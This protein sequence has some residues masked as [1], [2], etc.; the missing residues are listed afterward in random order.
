MII[1]TF[2]QFL[3]LIKVRK[4]FSK[5]VILFY[6]GFKDAFGF[7]LLFVLVIVIF[8]ISY[9]VLGA[10]MDDS[11]NFESSYDTSH[12]DYPFI[13]Y[14]AVSFLSAARSSVGDLMPPTYDVWIGDY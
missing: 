9:H 8:T 5:F 3:D 1:L 4:D 14:W 2:L 6:Q 7:L 10:Q 12:N 13:N 11:G